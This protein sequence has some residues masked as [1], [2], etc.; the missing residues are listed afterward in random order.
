MDYLKRE[1]CRDYTAWDL[2]CPRIVTPDNKLRRK[3]VRKSRRNFKKALTNLRTHGII[4][5]QQE[6]RKLQDE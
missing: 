2:N 6:E 5:V 3:F 1:T 4:R